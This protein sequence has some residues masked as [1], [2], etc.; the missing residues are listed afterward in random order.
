MDRWCET[1][2]E[3]W[4]HTF[5]FRICDAVFNLLQPRLWLLSQQ[6][7]EVCV[8]YKAILIL[9]SFRGLFGATA[10]SLLISIIHHF[11]FSL[12]LSQ[13][14]HCSFIAIHSILL[15]QG[16]EEELQCLVCLWSRPQGIIIIYSPFI[17][18]AFA[19]DNNNT[20]IGVNEWDFRRGNCWS[21]FCGMETK[22]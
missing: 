19:G 16:G 6:Q 21:H 4:L 12:F 13:F 18:F 2:S 22:K 1:M 7:D 15:D 8:N 3:L 5:P 11:L 9:A 20:L 17:P 14:L 10:T